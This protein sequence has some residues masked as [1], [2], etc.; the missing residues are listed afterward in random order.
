[1]SF[2]SFI[3]ID[4][5]AGPSLRELCREL[6]QSGAALKVVNP[7]IMHITLKFLGDVEES[8]VEDISRV[9]RESVHDV[10][11]FEMKLHDIG[12]FP[13][14]NRIRVVWVGIPDHGPLERVAERIDEGLSPLGFEIEKRKFKPH[15]TVARAKTPQ[16]MDKVQEIME[17]WKNTDFGNQIVDRI[18]LK[19]SV[20]GPKGPTYF[21]VEEVGLL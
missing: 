16:R 3:S 17:R 2:R 10:S 8:L 7:D 13:N 6:K 19:K 12:A 11:K 20:L 1:M 18:R 21:T 4:I 15:L 14:K 5:D 9:I